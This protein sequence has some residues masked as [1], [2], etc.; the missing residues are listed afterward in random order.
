MKRDWR[1]QTAEDP[2][3]FLDNP[4]FEP[5]A[6]IVDGRVLRYY[7]ALN[8]LRKQK[9]DSK[10]LTIN[11]AAAYVGVSNAYM[12]ELLQKGEIAHIRLGPPPLKGKMDKRRY[13]IAEED[14][15]TIT[16]E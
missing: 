6:L 9:E 14:L 5:P 15:D 1:Y 16:T 2:G 10:L 11:E 4:L 12:R 3:F 7:E 8:W 13:R